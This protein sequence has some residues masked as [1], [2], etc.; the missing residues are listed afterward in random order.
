MFRMIS[1]IQISD[2]GMN[3]TRQQGKVI[4]ICFNILFNIYF[5][6]SN[7]RYAIITERN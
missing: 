4:T 3:R 2:K 6:S 1:D 5:I 7:V